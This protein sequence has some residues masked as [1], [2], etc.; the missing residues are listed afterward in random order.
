MTFLDFADK[1][2]E[3]LAIFLIFALVVVGFTLSAIADAFAS[4]GRKR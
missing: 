2:T 1:H 3:G 4:R